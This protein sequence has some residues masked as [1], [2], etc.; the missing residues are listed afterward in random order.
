MQY[1]RYKCI[2]FFI[3]L[4]SGT[5]IRH[6]QFSAIALGNLARKEV[7]TLCHIYPYIIV[8]LNILEFQRTYSKGWRYSSSRRMYYVLRLS[9]E[10]VRRLILFA[11][12]YLQVKRVL[13]FR[14]SALALANMALSPT[15]EIVQ[16][17]PV[18]FY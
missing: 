7:A 8:I 2:P 13:Q 12:I 15:I 1:C 6:A 3:S 10:E 4:V 5:K 14:Y 18:P 11:F 17:R 16:V 9:E